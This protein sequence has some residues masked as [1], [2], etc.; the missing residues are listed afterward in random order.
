VRAGQLRVNTG[1]ACHVT[2]ECAP[3]ACDVTTATPCFSN[4]DCPAG[5]CTTSNDLCNTNLD[6]SL[7]NCSV[8][9][10]TD[11]RNDNECPAGN[12]A[13]ATATSCHTDAQCAPGGCSITTN[14]ACLTDDN[15]PAG[16]CN[17]TTETACHLDDECT[18]GACLV[19]TA[20][21]CREDDDCPTGN[22]AITTTSTCH[23]DAD[24]TA[25]MCDT[26]TSTVCFDNNDCPA[27]TC[28]IGGM[29]C[30]A[31]SE[32]PTIQ[33]CLNGQECVD[34]GNGPPEGC[35]GGEPCVGGEFCDGA[36]E[37]CTS[38]APEGCVNGNEVCVGGEECLGSPETCTA[39]GPFGLGP[40]GCA[41]GP[42]CDCTGDLSVN[43]DLGGNR[44]GDAS[45]FF[46]GKILAATFSDLGTSHP[47]DDDQ[48]NDLDGRENPL[49]ACDV[50]STNTDDPCNGNDDCDA[51]DCVGRC[52]AGANSGD[53]C[54]V[55]AE[56]ADCPGSYCI[57]RSTTYD[58][59]DGIDN[60]RTGVCTNPA[61]KHCAQMSDCTSG[62]C[63]GG[64]A[65]TASDAQCGSWTD[66]AG[67]KHGIDEFVSE[68][69]PYR[70]TDIV[71][72]NGP[73]MRFGTLEDIYGDTGNT[74]QAAI[75]F[76][77]A[78]G[79]ATGAAQQSYGLAL[80]DL[81]IKWREFELQPD[82]TRCLDSGSC[83]VIELATTNV[84]EGEAVL[85]VTVLEQTPDPIN[86]CDL[87][88]PLDATTDCNLSGIPDVVIKATSEAEPDGEIMWLDRVSPNQY[89]GNLTISALSDSADYLVAPPTP[90]VLFV[91]QG[92]T[93]NPTVTVTYIDNDI[94]PGA[95]VE[96][97]PNNVDPT[98]HG[99]IQS[100]TGI[101]LGTACE[102][103]VV[104][105]ETTDNGDGD[106]FVDSEE[107]VDMKV[108]LINNCGLELHNC[109]GRLFSNDPEV[110]CIL[111][112]TINIGTLAD[113]SDVVCITDPFVWKMA[114]VNRPNADAVFQ[115]SFGF[116]MSC[117]EI[118]ALSI[119]Q[120][121]DLNLDVDLE[122]F[123]QSPVEWVEGF[124]GGTLGASKFFA[125]NLDAGIP[126]ANNVQG[127]A[128]G[129]GW[130]CQYS[131]PDWPNSNSYG[132]EAGDDCYPGAT[133]NGANTIYW[134]VDG[135]DTNSSDGGRSKT[136]DYSMYYGVYLTDPPN[137]FTTPLAAVESV[138]TGTPI[139][140]G[141]GTPE[142]TFWHQVS[143]MDGRFLNVPATRSA[144][145]GVVQYK[146]VNLA[147]ADL[148]EWIRLE[149]FQN[150][151]STQGYDFYFNCLFDP[152]DDG[153]D[154]DDFFDPEDP[155]R[156]LGP[157]ST[158]HP[159]F[160][161]SCDGDTDEAFSV[162]NT[163]NAGT[164]P[165]PGDAGELGTGTWVQAKADLTELKGRRIKLRFLVAGLKATA[166]LHDG[167]F[168]TLNPGEE[169]NGWWIDDIRID[170]TLSNPASILV[171]SNDLKS[172]S[173]D[174]ARGCIDNADCE[175]PG[176]CGGQAPPCGPTCTVAGITVAIATTPDANATP[177][178]ETL[179]APGQPI[180]IDASGTSGT[181]L[182][183]SLQY[184]FSKDGSPD[185]LLRDYSENAIFVDAPLG[186]TDYLVDVRCSVQQ[187]CAK[188][189]TVDVN[190]A[191]PASGNLGGLFPA[192]L[193]ASSGTSTTAIFQWSPTS[194][195]EVW[196]GPLANVSTYGG[197]IIDT[198]TGTTYTDSAAA[199]SNYYIFRVPG[200]FCN[201]TGSWTGGGPAECPAGA[202][203]NTGDRDGDLP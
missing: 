189:T 70:N 7:G 171:D 139:N 84:F 169:D 2:A 112:S 181:C 144:D 35:V 100:A 29:P 113:G 62:P 174:T 22:C 168:D 51:G 150:S 99:L 45:C 37:T 79:D 44:E 54:T 142:L 56:A 19:S 145:R 130:R 13:V 49:G 31:N 158:C 118:N 128:N 176:T 154:E 166:E 163:C 101:L 24:C 73:D 129:D 108:C 123:G 134:S 1:T 133:L 34:S 94:D 114:N 67:E 86:D 183:G 170:D 72:F 63:T 161:W 115:G 124:E 159:M 17:I 6:C 15:C 141:V 80:D 96:V 157:S 160:A 122:D 167:Q 53:H 81:V 16:F 186:D 172:C 162:E 82:E 203:T 132:N 196:K 107:T 48:D 87:V 197:S 155:N 201:D 190:V 105:T 131:N 177:L 57:P 8:T 18:L 60:D 38:P 187:T 41:G 192:P 69:G 3:G 184:R 14:T 26:T 68:V 200:E 110:E 47:R 182:S 21:T 138:A 30:H 175:N 117:D 151:Y 193:L 185:V 104:G 64:D 78:E 97:C 32:C 91:A 75:G 135:I 195:Y 125:E 109:T 147:G 42:T 58:C 83:A 127:L 23:E 179:T 77:A 28:I 103:V 92:G 33:N 71:A 146:T 40:E 164:P 102:V 140:L 52:A 126:G 194:D 61:G 98:K 173:N 188:T 149:P 199:G 27:G 59:A 25:G 106:E 65:D 93:D 116:T 43:G 5:N 95:P 11:C 50:P 137:E 191:C 85:T 136:G 4:T 12:C 55:A 88:P 20:T 36:P 143:L 10:A 76:I 202:C 198:G 66:L 153:T 121:F 180:E 156:R 90:G 148:S 178:T 89:K 120:E 165:G 9:T 111:D 46:E 39:G 152:V 119:P 74:F